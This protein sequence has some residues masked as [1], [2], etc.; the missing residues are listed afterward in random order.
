MSA[1]LDVK[2]LAKAFGGVRAVQDV[3]FALGEGELLAIIGPNGAGKST[4][5]NMV[6]GQLRPDSG[7]I[8]L[9]GRSLVGLKPRQI[10]RLG[11]GRTFQI[12]ATFA[13]M[14][15]RENVQM[16]LLSHRH[17][18]AGLWTPARN[19]FRAE[20]EAALAQVGMGDQA[21]RPCGVLAYG[22]IKRVELA[23]ALAHGPRLLLMDEPTAGMAPK[24][25]VTLMALTKDIVRSSGISVLFTEHDMDVVFAH[26]D[27]IV[28]L[29]RGRLIASGK[30]AEVRENPEVQRIY[31]GGA[32]TEAARRAG[33]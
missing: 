33:G 14:T 12:T 21:D 27:R 30:P 16:V 17:R 7:T 28:V 19:L 5:F 18:L 31:L 26:A 9:A 25:R 22:D 24:E 10:W 13:S 3:S 2:G 8:A 11:V 4:C 20:A 6:G 15:V 1:V 32:G 29:D 23:V